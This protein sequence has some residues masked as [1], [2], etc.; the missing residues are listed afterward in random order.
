MGREVSLLGRS[1]AGQEQVPGAG[2]A[3]ERPAGDRET[4][5]SGDQTCS[6]GYYLLARVMGIGELLWLL[7]ILGYRVH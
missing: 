3:G 5:P 6:R 7:W 1:H 4:L 2:G